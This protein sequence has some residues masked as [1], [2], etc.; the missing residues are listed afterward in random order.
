RALRAGPPEAS[1]RRPAGCAF[2]L[3]A[4]LPPP[5]SATRRPTPVKSH[6]PRASSGPISA[7]R[8]S[9]NHGRDL[10]SETVGH[11]D[12]HFGADRSVF[13]GSLGADGGGVANSS[14]T[15][16]AFPAVTWFGRVDA[17]GLLEAP[18]PRRGDDYGVAA[19]HPFHP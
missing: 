1:R 8:G 2:S 3:P 9:V 12:G 5:R 14:A 15:R 13:R 7:M 18:A 17:E 16:L 4:W 19:L 10:T 11:T 6:S